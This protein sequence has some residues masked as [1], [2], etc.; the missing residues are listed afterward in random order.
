MRKK[1]KEAL[2]NGTMYGFIKTKGH[3]LS[4][5]ELIEIIANYDY[6]IYQT[7][8]ELN[9]SGAL[10]QYVLDKPLDLISFGE[11][12]IDNLSEYDFFEEDEEI[13]QF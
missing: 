13:S 6:T 5:D 7:I 11:S 1:I 2:K 9:R 3:I 8:N 4:K 12:V 10:N